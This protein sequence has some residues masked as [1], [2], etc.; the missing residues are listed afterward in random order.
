MEADSAGTSRYPLTV[1]LE[2]AQQAALTERWNQLLPMQHLGARA[3]FSDPEAVRVVVDPVRDFHRGGLGT[4]AV[5]GAVIAG[6]CDAAVGMVG[7]VHSRGRWGGT[8]QLNVMFLRPVVGNRVTAVGRL[9][10]AGAN[11]IFVAVEV[12]DEH[13]VVCARCD[14]I[15]AV[16]PLPASEADIAL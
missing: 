3:D 15:L 2:P 12:E 1:P 7:H 5:N 8:A 11:L 9:A 16:S 14:G 4:S 6:L 10:R 13:G